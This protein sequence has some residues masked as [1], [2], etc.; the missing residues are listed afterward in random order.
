MQIDSSSL[1][2]FQAEEYPSSP[3]FT[4]D[5]FTDIIENSFTNGAD[6]NSSASV[7]DSTTP[8]SI[9]PGSGRRRI[10]D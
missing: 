4:A 7:K 8:E 1:S 3:E 10:I 2:T 6:Q 9:R 5:P